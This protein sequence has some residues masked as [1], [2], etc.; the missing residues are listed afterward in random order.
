MSLLRVLRTR[1]AVGHQYEQAEMLRA[2]AFA[3]AAHAHAKICSRA[4]EHEGDLEHAKAA[5]FEALRLDKCSEWDDMG[6]TADDHSS[7]ATSD[8]QVAA[9]VGTPQGSPPHLLRGGEVVEGGDGSS[10]AAAEARCALCPHVAESPVSR[11]VDACALLV[12]LVRLTRALRR[13]SRN[14]RGTRIRSTSIIVQVLKAMPISVDVR[15]VYRLQQRAA[16][17]LQSAWR[18]FSAR[19]N[20]CVGELLSGPWKEAELHLLDSMFTACPFDEDVVVGDER[21]LCGESDGV[22]RAVASSKRSREHKSTKSRALSLRG[23]H[24]AAARFSSKPRHMRADVQERRLQDEE[25]TRM[26]GE[27]FKRRIRQRVQAHRFRCEA[28]KCILRRELVERIYEWRS[29]CLAAQDVAEAV[30]EKRVAGSASAIEASGEKAVWVVRSLAVLAIVRPSDREIASLMRCA[31]GRLGARPVQQDMFASFYRSCPTWRMK[32]LEGQLAGT[33][34]IREGINDRWATR[35]S[36]VRQGIPVAEAS[37]AWKGGNASSSLE[38]ELDERRL[39]EPEFRGHPAPATVPASRTRR[40]SSSEGGVGSK[41]VGNRS[42]SKSSLA[43]AL[44]ARS[45]S[46]GSVRGDWQCVQRA[47]PAPSSQKMWQKVK[48]GAEQAKALARRPS[49]SKRL[50]CGGQP[51]R[52]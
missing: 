5:F 28:A 10:V 44:P 13:W 29:Y 20:A 12:K 30:T 23:S 42:S 14:F 15:K 46:L 26:L 35:R 3:A 24:A 11:E 40:S 4:H 32:A 6:P 37:R 52:D 48:I 27:Q 9:D 43:G 16:C 22:A 51:W 31:H 47:Q 41:A 25:M 21:L 8:A 7:A 45:W 36:L 33:R 49:S 50:S 38:Q 34:T 39:C 19:M 1:A 18:E 17:S 2:Q